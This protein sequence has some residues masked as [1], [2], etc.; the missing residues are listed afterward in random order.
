M[1]KSEKILVILVALALLY[2]VV[3]FV[4]RG[5]RKAVVSQPGTEAA[6]QVAADIA[7]QMGAISTPENQKIDQM[8]ASLGDPWPG[9]VF[10]QQRVDYG[11]LVKVDE[12]KA[13]QEKT[14]REKADK[15]VYSGFLSMGNDRIAIINGMDYR[16]GEKVDEFTVSQIAKDSVRVT[17]QGSS[18]DL[19]AAIEK[20]SDKIPGRLEV[21]TKSY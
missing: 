15:L 17:E 18:F 14:M 7:A 16:V 12:A 11:D 5:Q 8:A 21:K 2:G 1:K 20:E 4:M 10:V 13:A 9:Q 3:D 19:P 6:G